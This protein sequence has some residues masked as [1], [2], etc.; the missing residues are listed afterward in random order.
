L[1]W[2]FKGTGT[3]PGIMYGCHTGTYIPGN[4]KINVFGS[5]LQRMAM[6]KN[7]MKTVFIC[8]MLLAITGTIEVG[9]VTDLL[10][11]FFF[12]PHWFRYGSEY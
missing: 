8:S 4:G 5:V 3:L 11:V 7:Y 9:I 12:Y 6:N 2:D 1:I 10:S